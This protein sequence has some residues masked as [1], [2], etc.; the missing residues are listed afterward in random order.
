MKKN[1]RKFVKLPKLRKRFFLLVAK[2][3]CLM[4][5]LRIRYLWTVSHI[6]LVSVTYMHVIVSLFHFYK[7][8]VP[9]L[10]NSKLDIVFSE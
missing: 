4:C 3:Y 1:I 8:K 10:Q 7:D 5:V 9:V 2:R 6:E